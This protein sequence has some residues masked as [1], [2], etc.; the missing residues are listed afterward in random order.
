MD[1]QIIHSGNVDDIRTHLKLCGNNTYTAGHIRKEIAHEK[2]G[3][4]RLT[5]LKALEA[6][7]S[8]LEKTT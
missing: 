5:V 6:Y 2:A 1:V 8:K 3:R 4:N 7:L